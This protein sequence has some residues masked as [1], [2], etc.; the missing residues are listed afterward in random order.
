MQTVSLEVKCNNTFKFSRVNYDYL[1]VGPRSVL[2]SFKVRVD[3]LS[4]VLISRLHKM[5]LLS[6]VAFFFAH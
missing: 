1:F 2:W 5:I 6:K 4:P 3:S